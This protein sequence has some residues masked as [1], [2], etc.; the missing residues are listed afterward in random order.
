MSKLDY[1]VPFS[2]DKQQEKLADERVEF[3]LF[4]LTRQDM[5]IKTL[6]RSAYFQGIQDAAQVLMPKVKNDE[7]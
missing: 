7:T 4:R 3:L 5:T 2:I 6:L 1:R